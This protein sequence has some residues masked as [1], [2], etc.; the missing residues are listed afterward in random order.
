MVFGI[1]F[2]VASIG[3]QPDNLE[4]IGRAAAYQDCH[5]HRVTTVLDGM[6]GETRAARRPAASEF[7][8]TSSNMANHCFG[9]CDGHH[10]MAISS[11][12]ITIAAYLSL[13]KTPPRIGQG[14]VAPNPRR[15]RIFAA[16]RVTCNGGPPPGGS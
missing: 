10:K 11:Y 15:V 9:R 14:Q 8:R 7:S 6:A 4:A 2:S 12:A 1:G 5:R 3:E 16:L 13:P